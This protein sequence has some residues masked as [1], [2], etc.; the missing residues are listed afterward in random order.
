MTGCLAFEGWEHCLEFGDAGDSSG[1]EDTLETTLDYPGV[2]ESVGDVGL[3]VHQGRQ[4]GPRALLGF[5]CCLNVLHDES[6]SIVVN[7]AF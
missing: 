2:A 1:G 6:S 7:R 4:L 3:A 5:S